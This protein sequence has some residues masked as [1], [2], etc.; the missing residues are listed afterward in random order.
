MGYL[1]TQIPQW[2]SAQMGEGAGILLSGL[3]YPFNPE[4]LPP[5]SSDCL[6][7]AVGEVTAN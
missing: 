3:L 6:V 7:V 5:S 4:Q 1:Q 2:L